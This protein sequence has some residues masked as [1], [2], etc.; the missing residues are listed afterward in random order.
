LVLWSAGNKAAGFLADLLAR[1]TGGDD[2]DFIV[3]VPLGVAAFPE[4]A[5]LVAHCCCVVDY[6]WSLFAEF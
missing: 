2:L 1:L 5:V 6:G 4:E 3:G